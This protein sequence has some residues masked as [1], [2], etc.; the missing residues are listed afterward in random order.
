MKTT[1]KLDP[2]KDE[3]GKG[4][5]KSKWINLGSF[6]AQFLDHQGNRS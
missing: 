6:D 3:V 1:K 5:I 4:P 2:F